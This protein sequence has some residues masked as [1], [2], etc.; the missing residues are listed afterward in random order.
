MSLSVFSFIPFS[1]CHSTGGSSTQEAL[2][3]SVDLFEGMEVDENASGGVV[4]IF[5]A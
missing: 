2:S 5:F 1:F 4:L 3:V